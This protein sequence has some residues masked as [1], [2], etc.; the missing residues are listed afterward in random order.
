MRLGRDRRTSMLNLKHSEAPLIP[1]L[2][3]EMREPAS[4]SPRSYA[5]EVNTVRH[6]IFLRRLLSRRFR[7]KSP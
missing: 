7:L 5:G 6:T 1:S 4:T 3:F 2:A